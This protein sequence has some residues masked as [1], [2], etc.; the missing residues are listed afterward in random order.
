VA[1]EKFARNRR[2]AIWLTL[3]LLSFAPVGIA[4]AE[5]TPADRETA[6]SL[7]DRGDLDF[8]QGRYAEALQEFRAAHALMN[9]PTTGIAV[10]RTLAAMG[11]L[12]EARDAAIQVTLLPLN[13]PEPT[14]FSVARSD[15]QALASQLAPRISGLKINVLG[16]DPAVLHVDVNGEP[17][18]NA[19]LSLSRSVNPGTHSVHASAPGY[20]SQQKDVTVAEGQTISID[21]ALQRDLSLPVSEMSPVTPVPPIGG[22]ADRDISDDTTFW[23]GQRVASAIVGGVGLA[24]LLTGSVL[25]MH[26]KGKYDDAG[27]DCGADGCGPRAFDS[28]QSAR[29]EGNVATALFVVGTAAIG[30]SVALWL[31]APVSVSAEVGSST[32]LI[33][34]NGV[35]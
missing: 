31:T 22:P 10:A 25:A 28:R 15:A 19:V 13:G 29:R 18:P 26:A 5:I 20:V 24:S 21:L 4:R 7:M 1:F 8:E 34:V 30:G 11:Q 12:L 14:P 3:L 9:V 33:S 16:V 32:S 27:G 6:R 35:F 17:V 2:A 23:N